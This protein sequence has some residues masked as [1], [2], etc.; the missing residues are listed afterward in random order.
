MSNHVDHHQGYASLLG[1][2]TQDRVDP[3]IDDTGR[4]E[5]EVLQIERNPFCALGDIPHREDDHSYQV[6]CLCER[7]GSC[8]TEKEITAEVD[9]EHIEDSEHR[10]GDS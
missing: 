10:C 3:A 9:E 1:V 8:A 5:S 7:D 2:T 4:G 6:H